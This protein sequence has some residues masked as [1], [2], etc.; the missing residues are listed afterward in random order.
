[1]QADPESRPIVVAV[2]HSDS[3][4][5]AAAWA[6][7]IAADWLAPLHLLH[8]VAG[9]LQDPPEPL[10]SWLAELGDV[11]ERVG[12][13][14]ITIE[15]VP[16]DVVATAA[17]RGVGARLLVLGS[18]GEGGSGGML[19]GSVALG[20]V[21]RV[22]CPVA[23]VRGSAPRLAP[24]RAGPVV[25]GVDGSGA[26]EA[27]LSFAADLA[28]AVG[29]RLV[30]I[31][32]WSDVEVGPEGSPWRRHES[33][34]SLMAE[35]TSLLATQLTWVPERYP[36]LAIE[37]QVVEGTPLRALIGRASG[38]RALV[39]GARGGTG[40]TGVLMESTSNAL[41]GFAPCPVVVVH[42][43]KTLSAVVA[44]QSEVG[45]PS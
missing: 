40:H 9:D 27:A 32:V 42:G 10:P 29:A 5:D 43:H 24:P 20:V 45:A 13:R 26:G 16:G 1:M 17:T 3:A 22:G 14:P 44:E 12:A 37:Q 30:A 25:V 39:V 18:Y 28:V 15:V 2:D 36:G 41:L 8:V 11:A 7:G 19:A 38:A 21:E 34:V 31:H 33:P 23:V 35:A 6:A 4:R